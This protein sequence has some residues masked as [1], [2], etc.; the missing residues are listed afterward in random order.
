MTQIEYIGREGRRTRQGYKI[1]HVYRV[2][3]Q[4]ALV[5]APNRKD[6]DVC[7][8]RAIKAGTLHYHRIEAF[9]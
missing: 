7:L 3:G 8:A 9:Q 6:A 1:L 2:D 5:R 4:E